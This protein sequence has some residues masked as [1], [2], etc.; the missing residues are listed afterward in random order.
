[1]AYTPLTIYEKRA[2]VNLWNN[3][4]PDDQL[5]ANQK[6]SYRKMVPLFVNGRFQ[7]TCP[8]SGYTTSKIPRKIIDNYMAQKDDVTLIKEDED[9]NY[10]K[11]RSH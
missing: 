8:D 6:G 4:N 10:Y 5:I 2:A 3:Q 7:L 1:M 11:V 9:G